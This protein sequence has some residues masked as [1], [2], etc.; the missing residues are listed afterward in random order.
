MRACGASNKGLGRGGRQE[1]DIRIM[2]GLD[3]A[4]G[5]PPYLEEAG[6]ELH[7]TQGPG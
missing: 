2:A 4:E 7:V 3:Q 1:E 6:V 5:K